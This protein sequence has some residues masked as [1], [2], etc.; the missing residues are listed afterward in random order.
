MDSRVISVILQ[1]ENTNV[2]I[3]NVYAPP[4]PRPRRIFWPRLSKSLSHEHIHGLSE[5][6]S[7]WLNS[8][9]T[10]HVKHREAYM[11]KRGSSGTASIYMHASWMLIDCLTLTCLT[12][13][14]QVHI[15]VPLLF[16]DLD[17]FYLG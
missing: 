13:H 14:G 4:S 3:L 17:R 15:M 5:G 2:G 10:N 11:T 6:I 12:S 16:L 8:L 9:N 1:V 7:I